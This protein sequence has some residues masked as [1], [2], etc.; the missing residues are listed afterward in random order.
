MYFFVLL[1]DLCDY[2]LHIWQ[3]LVQKKFKKILC[4]IFSLNFQWEHWVSNSRQII[5]P[6][7]IT[8]G[9]DHPQISNGNAESENSGAPDS[10]PS[11]G[12]NLKWVLLYAPM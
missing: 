5:N 2:F 3:K 4:Y 11:I 7:L 9:F 1:Q 6:R 12:T 10:A 8:T